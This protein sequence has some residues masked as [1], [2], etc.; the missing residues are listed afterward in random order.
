MAKPPHVQHVTPAEFA[1]AATKRKA[2]PREKDP[3]VWEPC[4]VCGK[5]AEVVR[6]EAAWE[7]PRFRCWE[8]RES[9]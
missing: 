9:C 2:K 4:E 3:F 1:A 6:L 7:R 8:C 5:L